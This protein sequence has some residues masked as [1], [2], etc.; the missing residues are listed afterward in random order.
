[1]KE[2]PSGLAGPAIMVL[3]ALIFGYF[4]FT[5]TSRATDGQF[6]L[7]MALLTWT[8]R[9]SSI[10][11]VLSA[12]LTFVKPILGNLL[13]SLVGV[14]GAGLFVVVAI[15]DVADAR[16]Q[17]IHPAILLV[18]AVWNGYGSWVSLRAILSRR[19]LGAAAGVHADVPE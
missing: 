19:R 15:M 1:M 4:G 18:F 16:Y 12:A 13:F 3:S 2:A 17:S 5:M 8:L 7:F 6:V 9:I 14:I 11:F 10:V